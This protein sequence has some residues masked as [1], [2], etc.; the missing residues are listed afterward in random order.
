M[1][2]ANNVNTV[3]HPLYRRSSPT[4]KPAKIEAIAETTWPIPRTIVFAL[5]LMPTSWHMVPT[6]TIKFKIGYM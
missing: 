4:V 5:K 1:A 2:A 6:I 3:A